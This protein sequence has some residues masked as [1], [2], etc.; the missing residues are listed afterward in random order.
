MVRFMDGAFRGFIFKD[1]SWQTDPELN[2]ELNLQLYYK[3]KD[4]EFEHEW[5]FSIK[6]ENNHSQYFPFI[7]AV[8]AGKDI[9]HENL[10]RLTEIAK[11]LDV[12]LY[13]QEINPAKNGFD[14]IPVEEVK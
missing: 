2:A 4:Y 6:N 10:K 14:Y 13:K 12:P 11:S 7:S 5:R 9:T 8:Y 3:N 1:A